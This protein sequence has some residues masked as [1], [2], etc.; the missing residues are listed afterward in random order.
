MNA[1]LLSSEAT[2]VLLFAGISSNAN[3]FVMSVLY[4]FSLSSCIYDRYLVCLRTAY[5][6]IASFCECGNKLEG[7]RELLTSSE[8][9][10]LG[11]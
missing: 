9:M 5:K 7:C 10:V 11:S 2:C 1:K 6:H 4:V 3:L 8:D